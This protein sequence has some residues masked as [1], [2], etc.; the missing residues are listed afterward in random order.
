MPAVYPTPHPRRYK[1]DRHTTLPFAALREMLV[2]I[3]AAGRDREKY[4]QQVEARQHYVKLLPGAELQ[5]LE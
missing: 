5:P 2:R 3:A 1:R 4:L